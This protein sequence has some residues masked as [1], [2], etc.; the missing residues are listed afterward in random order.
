M[1]EDLKVGSI[2]TRPGEMKSG[3]IDAGEAAIPVTVFNGS[4]PGPTLALVAGNHGYEYPP[5]LALQKLRPRIQPKKLAGRIVM[6][7]VANLPS[8]LGFVSQ[9][10]KDA[11]KTFEERT[12]EPVRQRAE[13]FEKEFKWSMFSVRTILDKHCS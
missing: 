8:F 3:L 7:H 9:D 1:S 10:G 5:I 6:V 12:R 4:K 11:L 13:E 2:I